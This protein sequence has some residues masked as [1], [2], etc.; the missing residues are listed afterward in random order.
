M[1]LNIRDDN[2]F[3]RINGKIQ[4][5]SPVDKEIPLSA[6]YV[7]GSLFSINSDAGRGAPDG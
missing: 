2:G 7:A 1:G 3:P 4:D 6:A 5:G